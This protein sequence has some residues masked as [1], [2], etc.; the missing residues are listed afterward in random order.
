MRTVGNSN[1]ADFDQHLRSKLTNYVPEVGSA[2]PWGYAESV[3]PI[4][5]E[6]LVF[7]STPSHGGAWVCPELFMA[8]PER[9]RDIGA[10]SRYHAGWVNWFEEDVEISAVIMAYPDAFSP[11]A[12]AFAEASI[13]HAYIVA[14]R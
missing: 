12:V 3:D 5:P 13:D 8:M 4:I 6:K 7:V 9:L 1:F 2:T 11:Q 14:D 10:Y